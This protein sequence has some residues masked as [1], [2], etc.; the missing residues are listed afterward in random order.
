MLHLI[1]DHQKADQSYMD[2][3][4][5]ILELAQRAG[6]L[7]RQAGAVREAPL[8]QLC[9]RGVLVE[10]RRSDGRIPPTL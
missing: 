10:V 5:R 8:A 6:D 1:E 3:G 4:V 2:E 7:F 9:T